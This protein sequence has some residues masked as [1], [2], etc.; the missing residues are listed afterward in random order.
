MFHSC[1]Q[2]QESLWL[3]WLQPAPSWS[4]GIVVMFASG[5]LLGS[6]LVVRCEW[7]WVSRMLGFGKD[8]CMMVFWIY[9]VVVLYILAFVCRVV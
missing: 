3:D 1:E 6:L 8:V 4:A 5:G 9:M 2:S 7:V